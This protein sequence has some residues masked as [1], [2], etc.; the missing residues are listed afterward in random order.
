[1]SDDNAQGLIMLGMM[2]VAFGF[3]GFIMWL[4]K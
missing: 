2:I 4:N 1:M 3:I